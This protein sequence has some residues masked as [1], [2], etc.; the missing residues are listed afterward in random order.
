MNGHNEGFA[1]FI[2]YSSP[3]LFWVFVSAM[4][5]GIWWFR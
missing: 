5:A 2:A 3:Y 4:T 1:R